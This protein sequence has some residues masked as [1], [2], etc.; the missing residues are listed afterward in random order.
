MECVHY[1]LRPFPICLV[2][3]S[4]FSFWVWRGFVRWWL[5]RVFGFLLVSRSVVYSAAPSLAAALRRLLPA[6]R[7]L[8]A[9]FCVSFRCCVSVGTSEPFFPARRCSAL[10]PGAAAVASFLPKLVFFFQRLLSRVGSAHHG[11]A[12]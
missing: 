1:S 7:L 11:V 4:V 5:C 2:S 3:W 10:V 9:S 6:L 8:P 12:S